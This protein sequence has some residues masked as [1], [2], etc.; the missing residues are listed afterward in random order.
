[1]ENIII[2]L[3]LKIQE[4]TTENTALK[5][6]M[7][8]MYSNWSYDYNRFILL[9]EKCKFGYCKQKN[10]TEN[11]ESTIIPRAKNDVKPNF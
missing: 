5:G 11:D 10:N 4:L 1:M 9:K 7:T 8:L 6:K 2:D 3:K